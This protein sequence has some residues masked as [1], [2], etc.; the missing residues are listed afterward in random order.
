VYAVIAAT[1][2]DDIRSH[3]QPAQA[4]GLAPMR[5]AASAPLAT[6]GP[7]PSLVYYAGRHVTFL[8]DIEAAARW[9]ETPGPHLLVLQERE[10]NLLRSAAPGWRGTVLGRR[11][12]FAPRLKHILDGRAMRP[13]DHLVLLTDGVGP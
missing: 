5:Q 4:L 3:F 11:P 6:I 10:A 13:S 9:I 2:G 7:R 8:P 12:M 1:W